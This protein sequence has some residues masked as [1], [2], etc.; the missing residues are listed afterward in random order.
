MTFLFAHLFAARIRSAFLLA[1]A[2]GSAAT[3]AVIPAILLAQFLGAGLIKTLA[4]LLA[5]GSLGFLFLIAK[6]DTLTTN[7][8]WRV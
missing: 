6:G 8:L 4:G 5:F 2:A 3:G 1:E 7:I